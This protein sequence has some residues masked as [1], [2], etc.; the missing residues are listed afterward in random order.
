[1]F[2]YADDV[3]LLAPS[4]DAMT[5]MLDICVQFA[6]EHGLTFNAKK[7]Q[8]ICFS[9]KKHEPKSKIKFMEEELAWRDS[10]N[11]LGHFLDCQMNMKQDLKV[12]LSRFIRKAHELFQCHGYADP[13]A[14]LKLISVFDMDFYGSNL[15]D[16]YGGISTKL[17]NQW[18]VLVRKCWNL[19][20]SSHSYLVENL[21]NEHL[22][23][24]L[25]QRQVSFEERLKQSKN[26]LVGDLFWHVHLSNSSMIGLAR[27]NRR[28]TGFKKGDRYNRS[29]PKEEEWICPV[30]FDLFTAKYNADVSISGVSDAEIDGMI[31]YLTTL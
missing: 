1:M 18:N 9:Q 30:L 8:A 10:V 29:L 16:L 3:I 13:R 31:D 2:G 4:L 12:K 19:P 28:I 15:W 25:R 24:I 21:C 27:I 7:T 20:R 17:F 11:H 5:K 23:S 26:T 22:S 6:E 14:K